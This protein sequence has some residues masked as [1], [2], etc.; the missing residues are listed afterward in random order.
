MEVD[1]ILYGENAFFAIEVTKASRV[2]EDDVA[3][4]K[5]FL[6]EY[7]KATAFLLYGG[8]DRYDEDRIHF[9]PITD[10]FRD[11]LRLFFRPT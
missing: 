5:A 2:R 1:F 6:S 11:A 3:G 9:T 7:P 10:F 4:L 8:T